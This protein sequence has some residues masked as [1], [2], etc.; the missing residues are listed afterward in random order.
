MKMWNCGQNGGLD[1]LFFVGMWD[2]V[3]PQKS[4][5]QCWPHGSSLIW[6]TNVFHFTIV[7]RFWSAEEF[8][9]PLRVGDNDFHPQRHHRVSSFHWPLYCCQVLAPKFRLL[10]SH[11]F[12]IVAQK[13]PLGSVS[14]FL[15]VALF[16]LAALFWLKSGLIKDNP[17]PS[18]CQIILTPI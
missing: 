4:F 1:C 12:N 11:W 15:S 13:K 16:L 2:C 7:H 18:C 9:Y 17:V 8:G 14:F 10:F 6:I 3:F 5:S